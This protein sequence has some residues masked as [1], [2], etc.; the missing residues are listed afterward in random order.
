MPRWVTTTRSPSEPLAN[1]VQTP[2]A[3]QQRRHFA[4]KSLRQ[5]G[6]PRCS[7]G[8]L[9]NSDVERVV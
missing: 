1:Q 4:A 2:T 7:Q 3:R 9:A 5:Q 8:I 6:V